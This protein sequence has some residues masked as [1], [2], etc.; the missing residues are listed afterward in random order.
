MDTDG[1]YT[2]YDESSEQKERRLLSSLSRAESTL[3]TV[4]LQADLLRERCAGLEKQV[5]ASSGAGEREAAGAAAA[6]EKRAVTDKRA[7]AVLLANAKAEVAAERKRVADLTAALDAAN[8][9]AEEAARSS[10]GACVAPPT[11]APASWGC[12]AGGACA[13]S[14]AAQLPARS[15]HRPTRRVVYAQPHPAC[16]AAPHAQARRWTPLQQRLLRRARPLLSVT[17][18]QRA[19]RRLRRRRA[20]PLRRCALP[21]RIVTPLRRTSRLLLRRNV[22]LPRRAMRL[23]LATRPPPPARKLPRARRAC[24]T[25]SPPPTRL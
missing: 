22:L 9:R 20:L 18:P 13:L 24:V 11:N 7:A 1:A 17:P 8:K 6:A 14:F 23:R 15:A 16:L 3:A 12:S 10:T 2:E 19:S 25:P 4:R 5:A 21:P